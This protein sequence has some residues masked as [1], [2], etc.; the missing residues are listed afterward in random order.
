MDILLQK[1]EL[2][3][4]AK[5]YRNIMSEKDRLALSAD[6]GNN[7][8]HINEFR[9]ADEILIYVSL[10]GEVET[11][12]LI[13]EL[14]VEGKKAVYCPLTYKNEMEF[15]RIFSLD[16]LKEGNFHVLEPTP[17]A[18]RKLKFLS[19]RCYC[20]ILPGLMFDMKGNRLGYGKGYYDKYLAK[21]SHE[22]KITTIGLTYEGTLI[23]EIPIENTDQ[24]IDYVVTESKIILTKA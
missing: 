15:Y 22:I 7:L 3:K 8:K 10:K 13:Q 16:D 1:K 12:K 17:I 21:I 19:E 2:R 9:E 11:L 6:I 5:A 14:L 24:N 4:E 23:K 20:M 18:E